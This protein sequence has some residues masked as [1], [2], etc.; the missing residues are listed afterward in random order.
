MFHQRTPAPQNS[1]YFAHFIAKLQGSEQPKRN[2]SYPSHGFGASAAISLCTS[3]TAGRPLEMARSRAERKSAGFLWAYA[4][5]ESARNSPQSR[6]SSPWRNASVKFAALLRRLSTIRVVEDH[7][8]LVQSVVIVHDAAHGG[9]S[10]AYRRVS[11]SC[12]WYQN[13][14]SPVKQITGLLGCPAFRAKLMQ[15]KPTP[16]NPKREGN[17]KRVSLRPKAVGPTIHPRVTRVAKPQ[18]RLPAASSLIP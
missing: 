16:A 2:P 10:V 17:P 15:E 11:S 6:Q 14:P 8:F 5:A 1:A 4:N 12:T 3:I 18:W 7:G 13:P 9:N